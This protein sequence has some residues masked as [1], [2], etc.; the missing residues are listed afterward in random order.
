MKVL[1]TCGPTWVKIDDVR[2]LSNQSTGESGRLMALAF[3]RHGCKVTLIQGPVIQPPFF[4]GIKIIKY[5]FFEELEALLSQECARKH[6]LIIHAAAVSDFKPKHT[7][8]NKIDSGQPLT[9]EFVKTKKIINSIKKIAP[10]S[11]LVGFKFEPDLNAKNIF[12]HVRPLLDGGHCDLV[13]AKTAKA[14]YR[15]NIV[16]Q[17]HHVLAHVRDKKALA[18]ALV[19]LLAE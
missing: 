15:A 4:K 19:K 1:I 17:N 7:Y 6:D 12:K 11:R 3:L 13:W 9:I 5:R 10:A 8:K 2:I 16:V 18:Q 14:G